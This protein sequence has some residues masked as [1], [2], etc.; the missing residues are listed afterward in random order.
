MYN[1]DVTQSTVLDIECLPVY[2]ISL[3]PDGLI[4]VNST[5]SIG[6][7]N[8]KEKYNCRHL[9][10]TNRTEETLISIWVNTHQA[11][12]MSTGIS[13]T[14]VLRVAELIDQRMEPD[15]IRDY[16]E[17]AVDCRHSSAIYTS[18]PYLSQ[19]LYE[20]YIRESMM[21]V[22]P[23]FSGVSNQEAIT[24]EKSLRCLKKAQAN[25]RTEN[26]E[27]S[28]TLSPDI[29]RIYAADKTWWQFH[30]AAM[31]KMVIDPESLARMDYKKQASSG[32]GD[33]SF[34]DYRER[35]LRQDNAISDYDAYFA[36]KRSDTLGIDDYRETLDEALDRSSI[37]VSNSG[38]LADFREKGVI[39]LKRALDLAEKG[40]LNPAG[41]PG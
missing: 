14:C 17:L 15:M 2:V 40:L 27:L 8:S 18:L 22:H 30:G 10:P 33:K 37:Y 12:F 28:K 7:A 4:P 34:E 32:S 3:T 24:M 26:P 36:V 19:K 13:A 9:P 6:A 20:A 31:Q 25:L 39:A 35:I 21:L 23:G 38:R 1:P 16:I 11:M 29:E 41:I 5:G